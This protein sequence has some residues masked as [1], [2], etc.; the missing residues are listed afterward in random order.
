MMR[1][2]GDMENGCDAGKKQTDQKRGKPCWMDDVGDIR[3]TTDECMGR[4][5]EG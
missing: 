2:D 1:A 3:G 5:G 4:E